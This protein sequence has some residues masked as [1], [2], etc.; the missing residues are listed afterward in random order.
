MIKFSLKFWAKLVRQGLL[1]EALAML[2]SAIKLKNPIY[3]KLDWRNTE[4]TKLIDYLNAQMDSTKAIE[5]FRSN[6]SGLKGLSSDE[7]V[8][9]WQNWAYK[10]IRWQSDWTKFKSMEVWEDLDVA[11]KTR[12]NG[13]YE[14]DCET[15]ATLIYV[16]CRHSDLSEDVLVLWGGDVRV[17][18]SAPEGGHI[19]LE[20]NRSSDGIPVKVDWCYLPDFRPC[21]EREHAA[22]VDHI[23]KR[24]WGFHE[25]GYYK[26]HQGITYY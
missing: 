2:R 21:S 16:L 6:A 15:G 7:I 8:E 3:R 5:V 12:V 4:R 14:M 11:L 26:V 20:Y 9:Y 19:W 13:R 23:T 25:L 10:N 22:L 17:A 18:R 24:W 1:K